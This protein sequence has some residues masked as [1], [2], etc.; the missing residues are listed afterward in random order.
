MKIPGTRY[1]WPIEIIPNA[2]HWNGARGGACCHGP[3]SQYWPWWKLFSWCAVG[4]NNMPEISN[5][6]LWLYTR[7]GAC[8]VDVVIDR[9]PQPQFPTRGMI[10]EPFEGQTLVL[11]AP[12]EWDHDAYGK[13]AGLPVRRDN[14]MYSSLW[15][16]TW[17]DRLAILFGARLRLFV[18][19]K[20]HP[21]VAIETE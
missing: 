7:W 9:R 11:G 5:G 14:G 21:P 3:C 6:R 20:V 10:A 16:P 12:R 8:H 2:A 15:R 19:G 17:R 18:V 1:T 4:C 13:C